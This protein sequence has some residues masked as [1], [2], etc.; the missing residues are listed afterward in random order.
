MKMFERLVIAIE[1]LAAS[2]RENLEMHRESL[3]MQ[4]AETARRVAYDENL[5]KAQR[6]IMDNMSKAT[7]VVK[8]PFPTMPT[9]KKS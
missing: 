9:E 2:H 6:E 7:G 3:K 5:V 4:R 1:E 8:E